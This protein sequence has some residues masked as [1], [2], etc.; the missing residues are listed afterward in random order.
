M[1]RDADHAYVHFAAL[2]PLLFDLRRDPAWLVNKADDP[3]SRDVA[4]DMAR[5]MLDWRLGH[6]DRTLA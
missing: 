2:P 1:I 6:A 5:R 3:G 4:L